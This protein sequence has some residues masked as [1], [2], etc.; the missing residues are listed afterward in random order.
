MSVQAGPSQ[1]AESRESPLQKA[2]GDA[3]DRNLDRPW[4]TSGLVLTLLAVHGGLGWRMWTQGRSLVEAAAFPRGR[5]LLTRSGAMNIERTDAF[6]LW[7]LV[8]AT[9][10]HGDLLHLTLNAVGLFF[11]GRLCEAIYGPVRTLFLFVACGFTGFAFSWVGKTE[12]SVGASGAVF[13]LLGAGI[14]FGWKYRDALP[15]D[16]GTFFRRNLLPW[17]VLNLGIGLGINRL[18]WLD[19]PLVDNLA[20]VGGLVA[21]AILAMSLGNRVVPGEDGGRWPRGLRVVGWLLSRGW[22]AGAVWGKWG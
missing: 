17:V 18:P 5:R 19:G 14:I 20:H 8:S 15:V 3:L 1:G 4:I 6:E 11:V 9:F 16:Q 13:G 12:L 7:R 22:W 2:T 21:G 10:L